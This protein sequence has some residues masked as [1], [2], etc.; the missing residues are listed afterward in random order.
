ME[1]EQF[2]TDFHKTKILFLKNSKLKKTHQSRQICAFKIAH[3][4][5]NSTKSYLCQPHTK[6]HLSVLQTSERRSLRGLQVLTRAAPSGLL[7]ANGARRFQS[8][9]LNLASV[10]MADP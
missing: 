9:T 1:S 8:N 7:C 6:I 3:L 2:S 10:T 5:N 4:Y